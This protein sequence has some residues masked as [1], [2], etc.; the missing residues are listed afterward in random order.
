MKLNAGLQVLQFTGFFSSSLLKI[1]AASLFKVFISLFILVSAYLTSYSNLAL[2]FSFSLDA[3]FFFCIFISSSI[4]LIFHLSINSHIIEYSSSSLSTFMFHFILILFF[5]NGLIYF[6]RQNFFSSSLLIFLNPHVCNNFSVYSS[7]FIHSL[8]VNKI[9]SF[10]VLAALYF[11]FNTYLCLYLHLFLF[12]LTIFN[13]L[14]L[15]GTIEST[16]IY[17]FYKI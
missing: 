15:L 2:N 13:V 10:S 16:N 8:F 1:N 12:L 7:Q 5:S 14:L 4:L 17:L 6:I 11:S 3:A 9:N